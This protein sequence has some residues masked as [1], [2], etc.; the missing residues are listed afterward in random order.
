[1][2][3]NGVNQN[4]IDNNSVVN[5]TQA[6]FN[7]LQRKSIDYSK[8][9]LQGFTRKT[10]GV[11]LYSAKV[12]INTQRPIYFDISNSIIQAV[13]QDIEDFLIYLL[14]FQLVFHL[15]LMQY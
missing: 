2:N 12:D 1:M 13:E 11:D 14:L 7:A 3:V 9:N 10:L 8:S 6:L 15:L 5:T 4:L